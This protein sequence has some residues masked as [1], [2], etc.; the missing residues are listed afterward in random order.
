MTPKLQSEIDKAVGKMRRQQFHEAQN[1]FEKA[2]KMAP[3][4]PDVQYM[5]GMLDYYQQHYDQA[6]TKLET[7]ISI[8]PNYER[9]LVSLG[10]IQL[11]GL[12]VFLFDP[13][14]QGDVTYH[15][16]GLSEWRGQAAWEIHFEQ[17]RDIESRLMTWRN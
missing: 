11:R 15:C 13:D 14:Y 9:A 17:K 7:A 8:N 2:A 10:E 16:D 12:G 5:W 3:G 4:N 1:H 6:R